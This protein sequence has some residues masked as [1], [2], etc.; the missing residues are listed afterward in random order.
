MKTKIFDRERWV[1]DNIDV[2]DIKLRPHLQEIVDQYVEMV[3]NEDENVLCLWQDLDMFF[4]NAFADG[5][6]TF[7]EW[8]RLEDKYRV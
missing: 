8:K 4:K 5:E 3:N 7:E 2:S 6:I 1:D